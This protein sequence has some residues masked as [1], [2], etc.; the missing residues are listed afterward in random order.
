MATPAQLSSKE[1]ASGSHWAG[2]FNVSVKL[3]HEPYKIQV[4]VGDICLF[5]LESV[6]TPSLRSHLK[7]KCKTF[8]NL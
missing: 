8:V 2:L 4:M 3:P 5:S 7:N 1:A 6:L